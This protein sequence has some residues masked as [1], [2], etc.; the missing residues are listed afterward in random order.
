[1]EFRDIVNRDIVNLQ[2]CE[3]EPIHI[4]GS[5]QPHG[6]LLAFN[7]SNQV[8][9]YCS[10][11]SAAFIKT[12]YKNVLGKKLQDIFEKAEVSKIET[13]L[14][15]NAGQQAPLVITHHNKP[16]NALLHK[17]DNTVVLELEPTVEESIDVNRLYAQTQKFVAQMQGS[18]NLQEL[19][20]AVA[21]ETRSLTGFDRVMIYRFDKDYNGEV[22]AESKEERFESFLG[23]NYPHTDIPVQA[24]QLYIKNLLRLIVDVN[25]EPVPIYTSHT[26]TATTL[27]LSHA[28][29][30]SVSPIHIS[31]LKNMGVGATLT[32]SLLYQGKLWGLITCH[33]YSARNLSPYNKLAAQLQGHFLTSQIDVR[34]RAGEH[35]R[36]LEIERNLSQ[37]L[38]HVPA[39]DKNN[40]SDFVVLPELLRLTCAKGVAIVVEG[41]IYTAGEVPG[42][43]QI[44]DLV[45]WL[46]YAAPLGVYKTTNLSNDYEGAVA[47]KDTAAGV[48]YHTL[49]KSIENC[50]VWFKP[51]ILKTVNWAG[52]PAKAIEKD[53]KGLS[54]RKSFALWQ[55]LRKLESAEWSDM[56]I[57]AAS[58]LAYA[59]Q[60]QFHTLRLQE[61]EVRYRMINDELKKANAELENFNW[62]STHDLKEPLRK[63]QTFASL[64]LN[65]EK[66][67]LSP[68]VKHYVERMSSSALRMSALINDILSYSLLRNKEGS[69]VSVDL[70]NLLKLI[71]IELQDELAEKNATLTVAALPTI[72]GVEFQLRQ[73]FLNLIRNSLKYI[74]P[75]RKPEIKIECQLVEET[76]GANAGAVTLPYYKI[77]VTDNG[78]GFDNMYAKVVFEVFKRLHVQS[79]YKGTGIGLAICKEI[80]ENH[81]GFATA[82]GVE[83]EGAVFS[84]FFPATGLKQ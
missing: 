58:R 2:N 61:E 24:R 25:Y 71:I 73:L 13:Y 80:M 6:F 22:F 11:N 44:R 32:I 23:L 3:S 83:N 21:D 54:P 35:D 59:M 53:E 43:L 31:Y 69:V 74:K 27:D 70:N 77:T 81:G 5:I 38:F 9:E 40:V 60:K 26:G 56:E 84:L 42:Q 10:A 19:C 16:F 78:I 33:H 41:N 65:N 64:I 18:A 66:E 34:Q 68:Q 46:A 4:P 1:M 8:I 17:A 52:D 15:K 72:N 14:G 55:E 28:I 51:E 39:I 62:I 76:T 45:A 49:G 50:I 29:Y 12:D 37:L 47:I 67:T 30:R 57:S 48:I 75:G 36:N 79:E 82:Y 63:I 20:Q 7:L